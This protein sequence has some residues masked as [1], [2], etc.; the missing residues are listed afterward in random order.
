MLKIPGTDSCRVVRFAGS[1]KCRRHFPVTPCAYQ[2]QQGFIRLNQREKPAVFTYQ[3]S[4]FT[5][6]WAVAGRMSNTQR[7]TITRTMIA[8]IGCR[9]VVDILVGKGNFLPS[10]RDMRSRPEYLDSFPVANIDIFH[11]KLP[12]ISHRAVFYF[13]CVRRL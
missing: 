5:I 12:H 9:H 3:P 6:R 8:V 13:S 10:H 2:S 11:F 1:I 4:C 7:R